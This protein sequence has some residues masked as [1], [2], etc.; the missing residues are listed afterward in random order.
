M[1]ADLFFFSDPEPVFKKIADASEVETIHRPKHL[2][3]D[4][5][6]S[7]SALYHAIEYIQSNHNISPD[8]IVFLQ[9]TSPLRLHNDIDNAI[10]VFINTM[11]GSTEKIITESEKNVLKKL[12]G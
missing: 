10:D 12:R 4:N 5:A 6:T 11:L 7:E 9:A 1:D 8:I 3:T 2:C